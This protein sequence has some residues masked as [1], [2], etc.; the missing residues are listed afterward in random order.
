MFEGKNVVIGGGDF[1]QVQ[2]WEKLQRMA[3]ICSLILSAVQTWAFALVLM[4]LGNG[5]DAKLLTSGLLLFGVLAAAV[6]F[7][8]RRLQSPNWKHW[9]V[10][11]VLAAPGA[12][13]ILS[14]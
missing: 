11:A 12:L 3:I 7:S 1:G 4:V 14:D 6:A 5:E 10:V 8:F 9:L 2:G 13:T